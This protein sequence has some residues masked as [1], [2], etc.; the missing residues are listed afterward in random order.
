MTPEEQELE[1]LQDALDYLIDNEANFS[2]SNMT[3]ELTLLLNKIRA[4]IK[5]LE[6]EKAR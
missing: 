5:E 1:F 4:R 6:D 2:A 3:L